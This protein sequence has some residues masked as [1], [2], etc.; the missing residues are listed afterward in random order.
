MVEGKPIVNFF[1]GMLYLS[2]ALI[3]LGIFTFY[4]LFNTFAISF[5]EEYNFMAQTD[6]FSGIGLDNYKFLL[7]GSWFAPA[8]LNTMIIVFI[9]VPLSLIL[10][11]LIS[12]ALNSIKSLKKILQTVFFLP[13][14]TNTIAIGMVF[15]VMFESKQGLVNEFV[16]MC[17]GVGINWLGGNNKF[18][19]LFEFV[20]FSN[21]E[22]VARTFELSVFDKIASWG[23]PGLAAQLTQYS[24]IVG[25]SVLFD[26]I[27][28]ITPQYLTGLTVLMVYIIWNSLPFKILIL[29][30][31][32]QSIDKQY[33]QAAKIDG[34]SKFKTFMNIT[35]P[36]VSPQLFYLMI[37]S[38]IGAWKEYSSIDAIFGTGGGINGKDNMAT[39][40]WHI[41]RF[42]NSGRA[43]QTGYAAAFAIILFVIILLFTALNRYISN[44]KVHY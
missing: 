14:V 13:Y 1:R 43:T 31:S 40:V 32:L 20:D 6:K 22:S 10:S 33:Y 26:K 28:F 27:D 41:Y 9:S 21:L 17:G 4:P 39:I 5:L 15:A 30:S 8:I 11:L 18:G 44:K 35:V 38:F 37:T 19:L 12:V 36:F 23:M 42:I 7:Q 24:E 2:P 25:L 3:L 16:R 29:L 34:A